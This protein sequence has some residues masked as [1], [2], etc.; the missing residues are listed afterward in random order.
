MLPYL[1]DKLKNISEGESNMLD[2]TLI[3][4]G[5][6]MGDSNLH[7]HRRCPLILL[8]HANKKLAGNLHLKAPDSTP[9]ANAMLSVMYARHE[10]PP[11]I[12]RQHDAVQPSGAFITCRRLG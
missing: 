11:V 7:N 4:Y 9:M 12:W 5:S 8:G 6:P 10:R 3:M 2:K 1:L